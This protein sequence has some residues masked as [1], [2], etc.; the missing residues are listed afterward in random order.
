MKAFYLLIVV[1]VLLKWDGSKFN[2]ISNT[3][4]NVGY[5]IFFEIDKR[6]YEYLF[7]TNQKEN[8]HF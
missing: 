1:K 7:A 5:S 4:I 2:K 3:V 8:W 6:G